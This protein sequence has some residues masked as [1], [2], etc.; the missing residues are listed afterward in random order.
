MKIHAATSV[1]MPM[2]K[3]SIYHSQGEYASRGLMD[4]SRADRPELFKQTKDKEILNNRFLASKYCFDP[5]PK[6]F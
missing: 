4:R 5:Y 6:P 3:I 1:K 2:H